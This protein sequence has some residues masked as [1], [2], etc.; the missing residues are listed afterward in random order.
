M[1]LYLRNRDSNYEDKSHLIN[2]SP[3]SRLC[4]I[5]TWVTLV[6]VTLPTYNSWAVRKVI[7]RS[8]VTV[9][10]EVILQSDIDLFQK[11]I[12]SKSYQELFGVVD[13]DVVS[14]PKKILELLIRDKIIDQQVK[15][16]QLTASPA[17]VDGYIKS[18]L[19]RNGITET[20]LSER[21]KSLKSSMSEYKEGIKKQIERKNLIEREIKPLVS[22]SPSD[23]QLRHYY[24]KK[25]KS[26]TDSD[27]QYKIAHL[28][29]DNHSKAGISARERANTVYKELKNHPED[30]DK[31]VK[32]YSDD[33]Q[34]AENNGVLGFFPKSQL[35]PEFRAVIP[36]TKLGQITEPIRTSS[37][38]H[39]LKLLEIK[40]ADELQNLSREKK[41]ELRNALVQEELEHRL[42]QWFDRKKKEAYI[43]LAS[44]LEVTNGKTN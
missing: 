22:S 3:L 10:D 26:S 5:A 40:A 24:I 20:Q 33:I 16:L 6:F 21:I 35:A 39:I 14:D 19:K 36:E 27:L 31:A 34:S 28:F 37:G 13:E 12:Q 42:E 8:V 29:I 30:F 38:F 17:E 18:I 2:G 15:K 44:G 25:L 1:K 11:R 7:D 32:Q 41:E 9:N 43:H 4:T 23:E